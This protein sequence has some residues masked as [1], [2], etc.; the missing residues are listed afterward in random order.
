LDFTEGFEE[1]NIINININEPFESTV[2]NEQSGY[3]GHSNQG[4]P[5]QNNRYT[6]SG[7]TQSRQTLNTNQ[8][9]VDFNKT[10][11]QNTEPYRGSNI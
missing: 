10:P 4:V 5:S 7:Y 3:D 6:P 9:T 2:F 1:Q 8:Q 11:T